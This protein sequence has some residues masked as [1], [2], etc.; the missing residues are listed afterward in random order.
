MMGMQV[1]AGPMARGTRINL[2]IRIDPVP[3]IMARGIEGFGKDIRSYKEPLT[4][5]I[6][7]VLSPSFKKNFE[8]GGR[9]KWTPLAEYTVKEKGHSRPL[10][11]SG[12]LKQVAGQFNIWTIQGPQG[13]A[14]VSR[15][16]DRAWY[17]A[18]HQAGSVR[19][20]Q[21]MNK[22]VVDLPNPVG[23]IPARPFLVVQPE[24]VNKIKEVFATWAA[25]RARARGL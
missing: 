8:V 19:A 21:S 20:R 2:D 10:E 7:Q 17:G 11:R 22:S 25:E 12:V 9:P 24:D 15:L 6:K 23:E 1:G 3:L 18:I 16:P 5:A 13:R 4:R 14:F